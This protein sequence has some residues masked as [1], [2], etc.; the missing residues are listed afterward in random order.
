MGVDLLVEAKESEKIIKQVRSRKEISSFARKV[1]IM[2]QICECLFQKTKKNQSYYIILNKNYNY[3][4]C[5]AH[6][7]T[8]KKNIKKKLSF[9]SFL[10]LCIQTRI[11]DS[12][13]T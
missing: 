8:H 13:Q 5:K 10:Q 3:M 2:M 1:I 12:F 6:F 11:N 4:L 9:V 7:V